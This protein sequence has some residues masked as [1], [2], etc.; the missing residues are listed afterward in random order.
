MRHDSYDVVIVGA[1]AAGIHAAIQ[2]GRSDA[3]ALLIEKNGRLGGV[4]INS[5]I[6]YP[7]LF[8][9]WGRQIIRGSG[10]EVVERTVRE[11]GGTLPDFSAAPEKH[12][13]HQIRVDMM[14]YV[15]VCDELILAA[16][17][18]ILHHAMPAAVD[19]AED[20]GWQLTVCTKEGLR[21]I[22]AGVLIDCTGD[23]NLV[24]LAGYPLRH[25]A[26]AQPATLS[27]YASGFD[28]AALDLDALNAAFRAAVA[29]GEVKAS[30]GG[31]RTDHPGVTH[32]LNTRGQ[33]GNH[34]AAT[35]AARTSSGRSDLEVEG[36]RAIYRMF[37]FLRSQPGFENLSID[38]V[39]PEIG[40]RETVTIE[41]EA[42]VTVEDFRT[43][44]VFDDAICYAFY[45]IDLHGMTSTE[46]ETTPVPDGAVA[47]IPRDA[48]IPKGSR[49]LLAAGR[50]FSSD[51]L[52]NSALRVQ[53]PCMAMGQ[54]AG[55]MAALAVQHRTP[56]R[57]LD[58][59]LITGQLRRH[60]AIVPGQDWGGAA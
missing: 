55:A 42:C 59:A 57:D 53:V 6:N 12:F 5:G 24:S 47:T 9:A 56:V 23:A 10:W 26:G 39:S 16:G 7:G 27:C 49:N 32:W 21:R 18:E 2:A 37:R 4:T 15:A 60:G 45:P 44:R 52:A 29:R 36:R 11:S 38:W 25:H 50:C 14:V 30:D 1:G 35:E 51:R 48:L 46:W 13:H 41:G 8:H 34:I 17:T 54:A 40:I 20:G 33:N 31:W 3:R 58:M 19:V 28:R 43:S 22:G